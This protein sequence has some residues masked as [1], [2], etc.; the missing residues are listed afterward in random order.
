[1]RKLRFASPVL[2]HYLLSLPSTSPQSCL[3]PNLEEQLLINKDS[4]RPNLNAGAI[5]TS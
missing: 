1:M 4:I 5:N 3:I 2:L